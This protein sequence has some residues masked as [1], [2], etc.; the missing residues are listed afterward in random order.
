VIACVMVANFT[1][2]WHRLAG[3]NETYKAIYMRHAKPIYY[4][5]ITKTHYAWSWLITPSRYSRW[6]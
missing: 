6:L 1:G 4:K 3:L 5:H 2:M